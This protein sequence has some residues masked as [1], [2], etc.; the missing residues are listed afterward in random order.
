M[1][2]KRRGFISYALVKG[3]GQEHFKIL[4]MMTQSTNLDAEKPQVWRE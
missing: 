3:A 4:E 2:E 1:H